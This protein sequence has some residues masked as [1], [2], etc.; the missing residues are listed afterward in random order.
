VSHDDQIDATVDNFS[1]PP[2]SSVNLW[3]NGFVSPEKRTPQTLAGLRLLGLAI[4][5][6]ERYRFAHAPSLLIRQ[7]VCKFVRQTLP[8]LSFMNL[9]SIWQTFPG[10]LRR[11][12]GA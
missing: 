5:T 6:P 8:G 9:I 7:T 1:G 3:V 2:K 11:P 12:V 10:S 4:E